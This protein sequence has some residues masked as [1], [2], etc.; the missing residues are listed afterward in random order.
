ML[1]SNQVKQLKSISYHIRVD[2]LKMLNKAGSGHTGGS[3]SAVEG[4]N[5]FIFL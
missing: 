4:Y 3:L 2:V 1:D 5:C